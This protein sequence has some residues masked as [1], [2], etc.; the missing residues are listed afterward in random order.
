[1]A[2]NQL[3][4]VL[5]TLQRDESAL[6]DGQLLESYVGSR[7]EAAFAALVHRLGPMVWRSSR[8]LPASRRLTKT[9]KSNDS[10][11]EMDRVSRVRCWWLEKSESVN[12][13]WAGEGG[14][15]WHA[16]NP[17]RAW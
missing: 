1:M 16:L 9:E 8:R 3:R 11:R 12:L 14:G 4:E 6:T 5:Q 10:T 7:E 2:T 17:R 13:R 15:G